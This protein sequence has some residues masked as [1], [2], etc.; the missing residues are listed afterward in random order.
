[1]KTQVALACVVLF[2]FVQAQINP[3]EVSSLETVMSYLRS[4]SGTV[5]T[6]A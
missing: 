6:N 4:M 5:F 1:M 3:T 2:V